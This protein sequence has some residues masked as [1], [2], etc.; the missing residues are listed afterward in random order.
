[1]EY[2]S[3][4]ENETTDKEGNPL[5]KQ[6]DNPILWK[7]EEVVIGDEIGQSMPYNAFDLNQHIDEINDDKSKQ[8]DIADL[9]GD[10]KEDANQVVVLKKNLS[11]FLSLS[12]N[13]FLRYQ[14]E[15]WST[16]QIENNNIEVLGK[17]INKHNDAVDNNNHLEFITE[18]KT[19]IIKR[20]KKPFDQ[21]KFRI[22]YFSTEI[23]DIIEM[24]L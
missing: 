12:K 16:L 20:R 14:E 7:E 2:K 8:E 21:S 19:W 22:C 18:G 23:I 4:K 15:R 9:L 17:G 13:D 11:E 5:L 1:M 10:N 24:N 3:D 6:K